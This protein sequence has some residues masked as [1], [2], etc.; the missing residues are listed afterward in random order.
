[1]L[2]ADDYWA[3]SEPFNA[4]RLYIPVRMEIKAGARNYLQCTVDSYTYGRVRL[5][6]DT[7]VTCYNMVDF[8]DLLPVGKYDATFNYL[9]DTS[10]NINQNNPDECGANKV[11]NRSTSFTITL[12]GKAQCTNA[13]GTSSLEAFYKSQAI[14]GRALTAQRLFFRNSC[15]AEGTR[16]QLAEGRV[17]PVEQ[18]KMGDKVIAGAGSTVLTVT[19]VARGNELN[20]FVQL[21]DNLG[22]QVTLTEMHPIVTAKGEVVAARDLKVRDQVRTDKGVASLTA[23]KRVPVN[24]KRVF[25]LKLGTAEELAK[26][27][28][29]GRTMFAG[30]FLVGDLAMQEELERPAKKPANVLASLPKAWHQD[31]LNARVR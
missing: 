5:H 6:A 23:V 15:M 30:G 24:G 8:K 26:V 4:Q 14:D 16:I 10:Y 20:P 25:N 1:V 7:G 18:V 21:R 27:D 31:Y 17:V 29:L 12:I 3:L 19:D 28:A 13:D 9:A 22:H 11:L 2:N